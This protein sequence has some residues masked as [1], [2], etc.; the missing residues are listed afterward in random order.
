MRSIRSPEDGADIARCFIADDDREVFFVAC[1][2]T[3]NQ[4]VAVHRSHVGSL[5]SSMVHPREVFKA[6]IMNNAASIILFHQHPSGDS[7]PSQ[8]DIHVTRRLVEVERYLE[9][10]TRSS[11]CR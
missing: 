10:T 4:V 3:K 8:E 2:N 6:A 5:N 1:L 9:L 7:S 11:D